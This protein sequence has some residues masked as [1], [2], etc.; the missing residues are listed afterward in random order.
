MKSRLRRSFHISESSDFIVRLRPRTLAVGTAVRANLPIVGRK[1]T[2]MC[3]AIT[4]DCDLI[5]IEIL[6]R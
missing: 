3:L 4:I 5:T 6:Q 2:V 1:D